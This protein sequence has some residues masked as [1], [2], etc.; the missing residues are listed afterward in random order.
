MD[1]MLPLSSELEQRL[2]KE[3]MRLSIAPAE[4]VLHLLDQH[5]PP[6]GHGPELVALLQSWLDDDNSTEQKET[7]DYLV[8]AL[9]E[10]RL[11][12]RKHF[13]PD[14]EGVTW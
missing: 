11:C 3:A 14:S 9:D 2:A 12:D 10:D 1:L 7:G 8:K 4:C 6:E 13:P 5:L